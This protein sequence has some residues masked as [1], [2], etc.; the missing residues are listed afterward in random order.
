MNIYSYYGHATDI[1]LPSGE[2][3]IGIVP[4]ESMYINRTGCGL[5]ARMPNKFG[6]ILIQ[7][8]FQKALEDPVHHKKVWDEFLGSEIE[9]HKED[10]AFVESRFFPLGFYPNYRPG[11]CM[12]YVSGMRNKDSF[13]TKFTKQ[14]F[15]NDAS[16][17]REIVL[18][19]FEGAIYPT[20][21]ELSETF[22]KETY[23]VE[24]LDAISKTLSI[25]IVKLIQYYPGIHFNF[26]CRTAHRSCKEAVFR[27][28]AN[29]AR[30]HHTEL[31]TI[32]RTLMFEKHET[33]VEEF[34]SS[35][36]PSFYTNI[37]RNDLVQL[38]KDI[39]KEHLPYL[40]KLYPLVPNKTRK[41]RR[42]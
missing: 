6:K 11:K 19:S 13:A 34:L 32:R 23:T 7:K 29:S 30:H 37:D 36:P 28:R 31:E 35:L 1:C 39:P 20:K 2:L 40:Q 5:Q 14:I 33:N 24:E 42:P 18:Q 9:I 38:E 25:R 26:L 16:I 22:R 8:K 17:S 3:R 41:S 15:P 4:K 10:E 12:I 21:R 27:H